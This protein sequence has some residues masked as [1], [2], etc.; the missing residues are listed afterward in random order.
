MK[1][2]AQAPRAIAKENAPVHPTPASA[3]QPRTLGSLFISVSKKS[4]SKL[5]P[6]EDFK[7]DRIGSHHERDIFL[8]RKLDLFSAASV[9]QALWQTPDLDFFVITDLEHLPASFTPADV[10]LASFGKNLFD[11]PQ[12]LRLEVG[13]TMRLP[14]GAI[15]DT[16]SR[17]LDFAVLNVHSR[18]CRRSSRVFNVL[19]QSLP[20]SRRTDSR[21]ALDATHTVHHDKLAYSVSRD[22]PVVF[23]DSVIT[24][25]PHRVRVLASSK[26]LRQYSAARRQTGG[27]VQP[28]QATGAT[29]HPLPVPSVPAPS[30]TAQPDNSRPAAKPDT[31]APVSTAPPS[32]KTLTPPSSVPSSPERN[33][34]R[35][36]PKRGKRK[37]KAPVASAAAAAPTMASLIPPG[38]PTTVAGF[39][40]APRQYTEL[41][42]LCK[43]VLA[44]QPALSTCQPEFVQLF[45]TLVCR[46]MSS[47]LPPTAQQAAVSPS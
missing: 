1:R 17:T 24:L 32:S 25:L 9:L 16:L 34:Q 37:G 10:P 41:F 3:E 28:R 20:T 8:A 35:K 7:L 39:D 38:S 43:A 19:V 4:V 27:R 6:R 45:S 14:L 47:L 5:P 26:T 31:S 15:G 21:V 12:L 30:V 29:S 33:P 23:H 2:R 46:Y 44:M 11:R 18:S 22:D 40:S 42:D 13:S 36:S